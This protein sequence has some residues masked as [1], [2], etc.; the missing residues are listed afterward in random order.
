MVKILPL[1][2]NQL[3]SKK[4]EE[5]KWNKYKVGKVGLRLK[6]TFP[7]ALKGFHSGGG[8]GCG[9]SGGG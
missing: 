1:A 8:D 3:A 5:A 7:A 9:G 4:F 2:S 6:P